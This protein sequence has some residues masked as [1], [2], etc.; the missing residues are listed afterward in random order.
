MKKVRYLKTCPVSVS[1]IISICGYKWYLPAVEE[2]R[3]ILTARGCTNVS[4]VKSKLPVQVNHFT[5]FDLRFF[6]GCNLFAAKAHETVD[7][8]ASSISL[9]VAHPLDNNP[10]ASVSMFI[11]YLCGLRIVALL[12][13]LSAFLRGPK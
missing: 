10:E 12:L 5:C 4:L 3:F 2:A 1:E 13:D 11:A 8:A 6:A 9:G 7:E